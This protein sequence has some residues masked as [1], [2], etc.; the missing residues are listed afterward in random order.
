MKGA[1]MTEAH[2]SAGVEW[3]MEKLGQSTGCW[4][5]VVFSDEKKWNLYGPDKLSSY[6]NDFQSENNTQ[7]SDGLGW[8]FVQRED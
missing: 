7:I 8:V 5:S 2:K 1:W 6:W 3:C 4:N